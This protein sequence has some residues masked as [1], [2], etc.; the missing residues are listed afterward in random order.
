MPQHLRPAA[1]PRPLTLSSRR[2]LVSAPGGPYNQTSHWVPPDHAR[3]LL[4]VPAVPM[5][6]WLLWPTPIPSRLHGTLGSPAHAR[7]RLPVD[8][9]GPLAHA[10][11]H[12]PRGPLAPWPMPIPSSQWNP[13][14]PWP[15]P[16]PPPRGPL[17]APSP[18]LSPR[19][20][21]CP[22]VLQGR[23]CRCPV[24][25]SSWPV[26]P[27]AQG[28]DLATWAP[29]VPT[30]Q[31]KPTRGSGPS[32]PPSVSPH[33]ALLPTECEPTHCP[34]PRGLCCTRK[35]GT[36]T[37]ASRAVCPNSP[38]GTHPSARAGTARRTRA[39]PQIAGRHPPAGPPGRPRE[40]I[41]HV[42][43]PSG[44]GGRGTAPPTGQERTGVLANA[45]PLPS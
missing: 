22:D 27:Q 45:T 25:G 14:H 38:H 37:A 43:P 35:P 2:G 8:P 11:P 19:F 13:G 12:C 15:M 30:S 9:W 20:P 17:D 7:P 31:R 33:T 3:P 44:S 18:H 21:W 23:A 41:G 4:P 29:G 36:H 26:C 1:S 10:H 28:T 6:P 39:G 42:S 32:G 24:L 40:E 34:S 5:D 16:T